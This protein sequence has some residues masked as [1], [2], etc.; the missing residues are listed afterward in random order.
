MWEGAEQCCCAKP[1]DLLSSFLHPRAMVM[2][3]NKGILYPYMGKQ[4]HCRPKGGSVFLFTRK[5]VHS[6]LIFL[7]NTKRS[8]RMR[9]MTAY[10]SLHLARKAEQVPQGLRDLGSDKRTCPLCSVEDK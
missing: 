1:E 6:V 5:V 7:V 10:G 9:N 3:K 8:A 4:M 2:Q